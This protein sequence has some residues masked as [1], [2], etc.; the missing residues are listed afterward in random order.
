MLIPTKKKV[1][2]NLRVMDFTEEF[3]KVKI[4]E[5]WIR[6]PRALSRDIKNAIQDLGKKIEKDDLFFRLFFKSSAYSETVFNTPF[7]YALKETGYA[8]E[9]RK[10]HL[11]R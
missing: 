10:T 3:D 5:T 11:F 9:E 2:A 6:L 8:L 4:D 7:Y 1:I